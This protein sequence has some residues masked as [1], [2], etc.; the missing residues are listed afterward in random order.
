MLIGAVLLPLLTAC[1]LND[2]ADTSADIACDPWSIGGDA[3]VI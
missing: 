3:D 2:H 1:V